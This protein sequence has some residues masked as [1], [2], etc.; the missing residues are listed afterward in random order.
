MSPKPRPKPAR[1]AIFAESSDFPEG[2]NP[3]EGF[4]GGFADDSQ[5]ATRAALESMADILSDG[6]VS[7]PELARH[8]LR[9]NPVSALR[10]RKLRL[11]PVPDPRVCQ[12]YI[13]LIRN[14]VR[15]VTELGGRMASTQ[16]IVS[17]LERGVC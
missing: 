16:R 6:K 11:L 7:A 4:L 13:L 1:H 2:K 3:M 17:K 14:R 12:H 10:G 8:D 5:R 15:D 9:L